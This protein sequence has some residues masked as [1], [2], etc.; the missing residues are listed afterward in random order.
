MR[1]FLKSAFL[2]RFLA[3]FSLGTIGMI[4][5]NAHHVAAMP[6]AG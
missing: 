4:A 2:R 5:L 6:W 3:G 1:S